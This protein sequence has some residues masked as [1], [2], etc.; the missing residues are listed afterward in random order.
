MKKVLVSAL[1]AAILAITT[2]YRN[3]ELANYC[4]WFIYDDV[5]DDL[6]NTYSEAMN[7]QNY[8]LMTLAEQRE[9]LCEGTEKIC[10]ICAEDTQIMYGVI[11]PVLLW[12]PVGFEIMYLFNYSGYTPNPGLVTMKLHPPEY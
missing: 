3:K 6:A 1:V 7:P 12:E 11:R 5:D 8:R 10:C 4:N 9:L 2:S